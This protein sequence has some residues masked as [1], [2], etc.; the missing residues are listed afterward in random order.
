MRGTTLPTLWSWISCLYALDHIFD[1]AVAF[2]IRSE[3]FRGQRLDAAFLCASGSSNASRISP[4]YTVRGLATLIGDF[5]PAEIGCFLPA[6]KG[7][8]LPGPNIRIFRKPKALGPF[9]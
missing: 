2:S 5:R 4:I 1:D 3:S 8:I 6:P 9:A 7:L